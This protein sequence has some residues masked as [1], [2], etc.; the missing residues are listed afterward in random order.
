[1]STLTAWTFMAATVSWDLAWDLQFNLRVQDGQRTFWLIQTKNTINCRLT[2]GWMYLRISSLLNPVQ[3]SSF[4]VRGD[5]ESRIQFSSTHFP[6]RTCPYELNSSVD[7]GFCSAFQIES[8]SNQ[9]F[10]G[11]CFQSQVL[12]SALCNEKPKAITTQH[13]VSITVEMESALQLPLQ[14]L[15]LSQ[16]PKHLTFLSRFYANSGKCPHNANMRSVV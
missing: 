2:S 5:C 6:T 15:L 12:Y 16:V 9:Q 14:H 7:E 11:S 4:C 8:F 1:M 10:L 13:S 3:R